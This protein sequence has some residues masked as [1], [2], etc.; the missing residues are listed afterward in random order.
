MCKVDKTCPTYIKWTKSVSVC[1]CATFVKTGY[2]NT[3]EFKFAQ[4]ALFCSK[5]FLAFLNVCQQK[6]RLYC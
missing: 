3:L 2:I 6:Q 1:L 5:F 4:I